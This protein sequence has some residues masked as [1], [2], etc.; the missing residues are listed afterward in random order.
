MKAILGAERS[1]GLFVP[2]VLLHRFQF[3][4]PSFLFSVLKK[5]CLFPIIATL[6]F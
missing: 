5:E 6:Y 3:V 4:S 2:I 1:V